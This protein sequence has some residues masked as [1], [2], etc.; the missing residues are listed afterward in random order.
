MAEKKTVH[1]GILMH[2]QASRCL[3]FTGLQKD[4]T[5]YRSH[6]IGTENRGNGGRPAHVGILIT[7]DAI[8]HAAEG[9]GAGVGGVHPSP[10]WAP[11][12][13]RASKRLSADSWT[14]ARAHARGTKRMRTWASAEHSNLVQI[15][16]I[17]AY[18]AGSYTMP[19]V[20]AFS[21]MCGVAFN[22]RDMTPPKNRDTALALKKAFDCFLT[23]AWLSHGLTL[24]TAISRYERTIGP[25]ALMCLSVSRSMRWDKESTHSQN[26][27]RT[28]CHDEHAMRARPRRP[29]RLLSFLFSCLLELRLPFI[30]MAPLPSLLF[31]GAI[32]TPSCSQCGATSLR[33]SPSIRDSTPRYINFSETLADG[34]NRYPAR[35]TRRGTAGGTGS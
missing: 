32:P 17:S 5:G 25:A 20:V 27:R 7:D 21:A 6:L 19:T 14:A 13:S 4:H 1:G 9:E 23:A 24:C 30:C 26:R 16:R 22:G 10:L 3:T 12:T 18:T 28:G 8:I 11:P 2:G 31:S 33:D 35:Q 29:C 34:P 15:V